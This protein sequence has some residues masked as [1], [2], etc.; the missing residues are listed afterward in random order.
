M[1]QRLPV[2]TLRFRMPPQWVVKAKKL[3]L[4]VAKKLL[5]VAKLLQKVAKKLL[6]IRVVM[7]MMVMVRATMMRTPE[8]TPSATQYQCCPS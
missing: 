2:V 5:R 1:T 8:Q 3:L 4:R 6:K 7:R